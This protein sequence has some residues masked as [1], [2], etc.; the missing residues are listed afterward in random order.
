M[1]IRFTLVLFYPLFLA[2]ADQDKVGHIITQ[3][4]GRAFLML[5]QAFQMLKKPNFWFFLMFQKIG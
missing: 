4:L 3:A 5:I 1:K 2:V